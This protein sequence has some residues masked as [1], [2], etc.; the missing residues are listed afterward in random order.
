LEILLDCESVFV[1]LNAITEALD[2]QLLMLYAYYFL[3][4]FAAVLFWFVLNS[5]MI[6]YAL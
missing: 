3:A 4:S 5:I 2:Y 6:D 1:A